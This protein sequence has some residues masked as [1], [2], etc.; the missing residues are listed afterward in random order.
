MP[1]V[2]TRLLREVG[3]LI[4]GLWFTLTQL[5]SGKKRAPLG[6]PGAKMPLAASKRATED[7]L[8]TCAKKVRALM[9]IVLRM[10]RVIGESVE[11]TRVLRA[12]RPIQRYFQARQKKRHDAARVL[13]AAQRNA[14]QREA[15]RAAAEA[16]HVAVFGGVVL[17]I[18]PSAEVVVV[19]SK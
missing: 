7:E 8:A 18:L 11:A 12:G 10:S 19:S 6:K 17:L 14:I 2:L 13:Q 15:T 16:A 3:Y 1:V 4:I 5:C 9:G